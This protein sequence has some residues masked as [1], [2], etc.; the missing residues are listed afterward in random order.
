M[1]TTNSIVYELEQ[2]LKRHINSLWKGDVYDSNGDLLQAAFAPVYLSNM[3]EY[4]DKEGTKRTFGPSICR[5]G[6]V[7]EDILNLAG[8]SVVPS[9]LIEI[10]PNDFEEVEKWRHTI[11][12]SFDGAANIDNN[13]Y[14]FEIGSTHKMHR[15]LLLK[16]EIYFL[17]SDQDNE[18]VDRLGNNASAFLESAITSGTMM[19]TEYCWRMTDENGDIITD[20]FGETPFRSLPVI[21]HSRRRGGG[22]D[23]YIW[24]I[25]IYIEVQ[26]FKEA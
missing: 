15:R 3:F 2:S 13:S 11:Y 1:T 9:A 20:S 16:M 12:Q 7:Q 14:L 19:D 26:C 6:R 18:E 17:E 4:I 10:T 21:V 5:I 23:N 22:P 25:K 8:S 24:D